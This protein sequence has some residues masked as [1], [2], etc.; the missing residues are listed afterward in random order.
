MKVDLQS[1]PEMKEE[2][3]FSNGV[4]G[5]YTQTFQELNLVSLDEDLR[6]AFPD[7]ASVN[8]ALRSLLD[9]RRAEAEFRKAG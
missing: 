2:Y 9:A 8:A 5:A 4:R 1:S 6:A 7:S 3:D